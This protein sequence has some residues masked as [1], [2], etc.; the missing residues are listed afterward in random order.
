MPQVHAALLRTVTSHG[1]VISCLMLEPQMT[2]NILIKS[3]SL[4]Q[5]IHCS[6][7]HIL[8]HPPSHNALLTVKSSRDT[9]RVEDA[10]KCHANELINKQM[11][12]LTF[13][14]VI[15]LIREPVNL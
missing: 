3:S 10:R 13:S 8:P 5:A 1:L 15:M 7:T 11:L 12:R 2:G 6:S 4:P 14:N 9:N